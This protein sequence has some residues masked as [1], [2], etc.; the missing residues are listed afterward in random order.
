MFIVVLGGGI[1]LKGQLPSHVYPR[2]EEAFRLYQKLKDAKVVLSGKF[3]FLYH[4]LGKYPSITEAEKMA[5]YLIKKGVPKKDILLEK[6]SMDTISNAYY[7]KK[8]F[9]L[10][11]KEK[12]AIIIT[13][14]FHLERVKYI[15]KKI[16]GNNYKLKFIG[17]EEKLASD[18]KRKIS[19]RQKQLL[20]KIKKILSP[21]KDGDHLFLKG[22]FYKIKY[23]REKRPDWVIDF[24]AQGK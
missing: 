6:K 10:P 14:K 22:K 18:K 4:Q 23:Y 3:S 17:V 24:V 2:L 9:F 8:D 7:L 16:F 1:S 5:R 13:S 19:L 20:E 12:K 21:M 15:F 11:K